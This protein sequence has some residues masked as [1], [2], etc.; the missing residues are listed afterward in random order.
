VGDPE[1]L[2][3]KELTMNK[4]I[5]AA[6]LSVYLLAGACGSGGGEAS[7]P[8]AITPNATSVETTP[9]LGAEPSAAPAE[10]TC[11]PTISP[12]ADVPAGV[13][14][15]FDREAG[16]LAEGLAIDAGGNILITFSPLGQLLRAAPGSDSFEV[17]GSIPD[18]TGEGLGML[19][20]AVHD[21]G[22]VFAAVDS[23]GSTGVW[24][25]ECGAGEPELILGTEDIGLPNSLVFDADGNLFITDSNSGRGGQALG[26]VWRIATDGAITKWL[27][28]P[29]L[30]GTD[31][32][33]LGPIGANGIALYEDSLLITST[34]TNQVFAVAKRDDGTPG[35]I[36]VLAD[37]P[38]IFAP[39]GLTV[40]EQG[41]I[42]IAMAGPS[43]IALLTADGAVQQVAQGA[44]DGL[45]LPANVA[46]A[47]RSNGSQV[48]YATNVAIFPDF[49]TGVGP[50][51]VAVDPLPT[52]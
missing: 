34:D 11:V 22:D 36:T 32:F 4:R 28:D 48:I 7:T 51:L 37:E 38:D 8:S 29:L 40:D 6:T 18:W 10:A 35:P 33:G 42:Y 20:L 44:N 1:S 25:F 5:L 21:D 19:G 3:T 30:G 17:V 23:V 12:G 15:A 27:E 50:A 49:G 31:P 41:N 14:A 52:N 9:T 2:G 46:L 16:Q 45:D 26:A 47:T 24:R 39:D 13:V 43:A